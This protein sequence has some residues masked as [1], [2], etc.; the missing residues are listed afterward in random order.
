MTHPTRTTRTASV[1]S[2]LAALIATALTAMAPLS[3]AGASTVN[4]VKNGS[5][6]VTT[7]YGQIG[8]HGAYA[9][10]TVADWSTAGYNFVFAQGTAD[11]PGTPSVFGNDFML[12]GAA[13]GGN[14]A[15]ATS[16][17]GGNFIGAD[18]AFQVDPIWQ[19]ID[20]LVIG[21]TYQVNFE[22]A[23][24]QQYGFTGGTTEAW[25]VNL[26]NDPMTRQATGIYSNASHSSSPWM[27]ESFSFTATSAS[28]V[29]S[30]VA[31]G[32]PAGEP[33]FSLL[34]G[35]SMFDTTTVPEPASAALI[36]GGLL[37]AGAATRRKR[38]GR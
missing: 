36:I 20:G 24:A 34:D 9:G 30:F 27:Q 18:G 11:L 23:A 16:H 12:W 1:A 32:T 15:L 14:T 38:A 17:D 22:W 13:N 4:L 3:N 28:E 7:G 37:A 25:I 21:H 33:P 8:V 2:A 10:P 35:V 31:Q 19:T 29:L 5:F 6:D 26:G